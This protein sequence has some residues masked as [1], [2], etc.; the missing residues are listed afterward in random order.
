M[1]DPRPIGYWL[2][3]VDTLVNE[4]FSRTLD[5]HGVT[6]VQWQLLNVL[7][8]GE[9]T[10]EQLDASLRPFLVAD[11]SE[12]AIDHLTEL[13]ESGWVDATGGGY[14]LTERGHGARDRLTNVVAA[15]RTDMTAGVSEAD[16]LAAIGTLERIARNLGWTDEG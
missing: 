4:Q 1:A 7:A 16:Y 14:E 10:V 12:S 6:R 11:G 8:S 3:L 5:E 15:Q 9:S 2:R 13:I